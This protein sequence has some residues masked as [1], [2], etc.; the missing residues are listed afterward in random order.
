MATDVYPKIFEQPGEH[1]DEVETSLGLAFFPE[2]LHV[3]LADDGAAR[4]SRFGGHQSRLDQH[5]PALASGHDQDRTG[6][7]SAPPLRRDD[8][9]WMCW[10]N[11]SQSFWSIS[12]RPRWTTN[13]RI[14]TLVSRRVVDPRGSANRRETRYLPIVP[15]ETITPL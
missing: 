11:A 8:G 6:K 2:L 15:Y 5:Y 13:S 9:S 12:P 10:S 14:K 7:P 1:A 4:P 3:E